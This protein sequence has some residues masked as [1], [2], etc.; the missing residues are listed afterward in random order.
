MDV[1]KKIKVWAVVGPTAS[2]K[3]K[4]AVALAKHLNGEIVNADSMQVYKEMNIA[5]AKPTVEEQ[6]GVPHHLMDFLPPDAAYSV[7]DYVQDA[8]R[9]IAEIAARKK[10][11]ILVGGTGLYYSALLDNIQFTETETNY[12][13][14]AKLTQEAEADGGEALYQKLLLIDPE[15]AKEIHPHNFVRLVRALE[16]YET[17]GK[18]LSQLKQESRKQP[19]P[20]QSTVIGLTYRN[21]QMLYDRIN[22]RVDLM[23]QAGL[24]QEA[25][26][27][28][29]RSDLKTA[30]NAI[31]YKELLPYFQGNDSLDSCLERIKQESRHYAKRQLTWFRRDERI[32]WLYVDETASFDELF[33]NAKKIL[34]N[35]FDL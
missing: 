28:L 15:A 12:A 24:L 35:S 9:V 17:T 6:E 4:L 22:L 26:Q 2:G 27:V 10:Q 14:R 5:T 33:E 31:G 20:Y 19:S 30:L 18:T 13:L 29:Q 16:L 34:E 1:T 7:S 11:P 8:H 21:R 25:Q 32:H 3:T 23:V